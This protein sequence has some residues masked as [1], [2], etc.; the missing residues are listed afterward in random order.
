[1]RLSV[2][3]GSS[4]T[5]LAYWT[6]DGSLEIMSSIYPVG[7]D[8]ESRI[9]N[10]IS[11]FN[12]I[13][14]TKSTISTVAIE[15]TIRYQPRT[16]NES[17]KKLNL[18]IGALLAVASVHGIPTILIDKNTM[19]KSDAAMVTKMILKR[20][21]NAKLLSHSKHAIDAVLIGYL[22]HFEKPIQ[23]E[24]SVMNG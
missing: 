11:Q 24:K 3:P 13:F 6:D 20:S 1:M 22:A 12:A 18:S 7:D 23:N 4:A 8:F 16:K 9:Q 17:L 5:G 21:P 19:T 15:N 2:D 10:L 14:V